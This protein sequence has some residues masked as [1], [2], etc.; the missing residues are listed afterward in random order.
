MGPLARMCAGSC[1]G[2]LLGPDLLEFPAGCKPPSS[3][4]R[5][6]A[7]SGF[8]LPLCWTGGATVFGAGGA[9]PVIPQEANSIL[10]DICFQFML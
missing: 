9:A 5:G 7:G 6:G 2:G 3:G 8:A 10:L 4:S 1:C